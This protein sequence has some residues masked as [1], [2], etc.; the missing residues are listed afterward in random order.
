ME[1]TQQIPATKMDPQIDL[2]ALLPC[3]NK[4]E[5]GRESTSGIIWPVL[6]EVLRDRGIE[7][8]A[9][10]GPPLH[11][12]VGGFMGNGCGL[13]LYLCLGLSAALFSA[14]FLQRGA[15]LFGAF[16]QPCCAVLGLEQISNAC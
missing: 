5:D 6:S 2:G 1:K 12:H 4:M 14:Y 7:L 16:P 9:S 15:E 11:Q 8:S 13:S 3:P 10:A